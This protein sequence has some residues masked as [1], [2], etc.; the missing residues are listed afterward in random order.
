MLIYL[1][2]NELK[3]DPQRGHSSPL[4]LE[5]IPEFPR[6]SYRTNSNQKQQNTCQA[7]KTTLLV[8]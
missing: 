3:C 8:I 2:V 4:R 1:K 7:F 6:H 5:Q